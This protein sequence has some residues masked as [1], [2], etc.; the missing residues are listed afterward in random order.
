MR[1]VAMIPARSGSKGFPNKNIARFR[2]GCLTS[3]QIMAAQCCMEISEV[4]LNSDSLE[5][6]MTGRNMGC[7]VYPR[8]KRL[9]A[10]KVSM[11][12]VCIDFLQHLKKCEIKCDALLVLY[13][14]YP[15][16]ETSDLKRIIEKF[17]QQPHLPLIG[18]KKP[19]T[20]PY[21]CYQIN[22]GVISQAVDHDTDKVFRRQDYPE[23]W[24][25]CHFACMFPTSMIYALNSQLISDVVN[26]YFIEDTERTIDID[27]HE[28]LEKA[29]KYMRR[30]HG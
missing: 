20:H 15:L 5:Y 23:V 21:R 26:P 30:W 16:R 13:P 17:K 9:A 8:E 24:E 10:D 1:I 22:S 27:S 11:K 29:E 2:G 3:H 7:E 28:D 25:I 4:F 6:L 12:A 19:S 14:T 18:F